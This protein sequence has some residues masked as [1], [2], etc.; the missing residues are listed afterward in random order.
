MKR[1]DCVIIGQGLAGTTLAWQLRRRG[2]R[3]LV[4]DREGI[5]SA[6]RI[7]AGLITPVTGKRLAK[8]WRWDELYP[9][10]TA[11]YRKLEE[12]T[13]E[14]FLHKR[15]AL[16]LFIDEAERDEFHRRSEAMLVGLVHRVESSGDYFDAPFG[17]FEMPS[18][19]RLDVPHYLDVSREHFRQSG[20]Y[21]AAELEL[22]HDV[23]LLAAG[24]C[25]P[26]LEVAARWLVFCQGFTPASD[27]WFGSIRFNA[28]KGEILTLR[29]P[30]L[31]EDRVI[32]RGVWLA[33]VGGE[34]FRCGATYTWDD[35]NCTP[36]PEG[37]AEIE[38]RLRT[39]L[40]L[41]FEVIDHQAAVRPV[42]DAG[43]PVLGCHPEFPQLAYFNGLGSKG[44]LLA[45]FFAEQLAACL[46]GERE[47]DST[48]DVR[49]FLPK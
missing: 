46:A 35:L 10:A 34:V 32:H 2:L 3:V 14:A 7:A 1:V 47:V 31:H 19:A 21:L 4:I 26:K 22:P 17:G 5:G 6:S 39:F 48:V 18:A 30:G 15:A 24:V 36:T 44:S 43:Y 29:I 37:R 25:L 49:K 41:P 45:P 11:F 23:E 8:S 27:P 20:A 16:R 9:V 40:R 13:G 38:S 12:E 42:I 33:P 28:A